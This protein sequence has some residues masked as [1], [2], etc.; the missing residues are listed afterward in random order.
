MTKLGG[1]QFAYSQPQLSLAIDCTVAYKVTGLTVA[2]GKTYTVSVEANTRNGD[3][4]DRTITIV[5]V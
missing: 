1:K 5:G 3:F 2:K 4:L